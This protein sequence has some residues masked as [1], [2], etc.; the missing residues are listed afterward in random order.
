M[1]WPMSLG[2]VLAMGM[3]A[4]AETV[5]TSPAETATAP[6]SNRAFGEGLYV[7]GDRSR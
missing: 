1:R 7:F 4:I 5:S 3:G 6:A 2:V